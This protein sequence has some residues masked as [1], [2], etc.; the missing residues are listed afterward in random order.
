MDKANYKSEMREAVQCTVEMN[1]DVQF[2]QL[3]HYK[4]KI[5]SGG[6]YNI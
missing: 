1:N 5:V 2:D 6:H 4:F 3:F